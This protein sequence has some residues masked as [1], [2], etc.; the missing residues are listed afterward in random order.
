MS[1]EHFQKSLHN[2]NGRSVPHPQTIHEWEDDMKKW[3][4]ITYEDIFNYFVLSLGADGST[5]RNYKSTEA[6]QYLHSGKVGKV[7][8]NNNIDDLIFMK[9]DVQPSQ[10]KSDVHSAWILTTSA[11]TIETAGC[12]CV[13]GQGKSCSHAAAILWKVG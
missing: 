9:A 2:R 5:M 1:W 3:P 10:S 6:Y 4:H 12:S 13:A 8:I 11:G 7:L